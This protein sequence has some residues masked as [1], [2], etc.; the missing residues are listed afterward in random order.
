MFLSTLG[1]MRATSSTTGC[2]SSPVSPR[3]ISQTSTDWAPWFVVPADHNWVRNLAVAQLLVHAL[4]PRL[5]SPDPAL[6]GRR[7]G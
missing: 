2:A 5:P 7:I 3:V 4:D 1:S 6:A